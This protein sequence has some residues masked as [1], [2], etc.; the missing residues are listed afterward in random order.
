MI[1]WGFDPSS[2]CGFA[3]LDVD[4]DL[5]S[6][7]CEVIDGK[8]WDYYVFA[9]QMGRVL[10]E[11]YK[12][13]G[14]P[15]LIV[16]EQGSESTQGTGI[17]GIIWAWNCIGA[18]TSF[19]GIMGVPICTIWPATWRKPF[20]G[21]DFVPPQVEVTETVEIN[22][23]KVKRQVIK[24]GRPQFKNDW[25]AAVIQKCERDGVTLPPLKATAHNAGEAL[26]IA[27][28]WAHASIIDSEFEDAFIAMKK[29]RNDKAPAAGLPLFGAAA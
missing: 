5:S 16:I 18:V 3:V 9:S 29:A 19:A 13:F 17:N 28:S 1:V 23:H 26:G 27:H 10:K 25:K 2:H 24:N 8:D 4:R 20:Y 15:D 7:H 21:K 22:G 11:R 14:K 6:A 12:T